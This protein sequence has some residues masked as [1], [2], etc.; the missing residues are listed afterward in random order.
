[1]ADS[2]VLDACVALKWFLPED[3]SDLAE[4]ILVAILAEEVDVYVPHLFRYEVCLRRFGPAPPARNI[5]KLLTRLPEG[6]SL[7]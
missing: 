6:N 3:D 7:F 5:K 4:D 1:M 2:L